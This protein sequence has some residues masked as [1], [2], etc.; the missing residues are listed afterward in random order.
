MQVKD[1]L[2]KI[3]SK[4][5]INAITTNLLLIYYRNN[6]SFSDIYDINGNLIRESTL[7]DYGLVV[8]ETPD[9]FFEYIPKGYKIQLEKDMQYDFIIKY[10]NIQQG[11]FND[12]KFDE[13]P[14]EILED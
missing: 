12:D 9:E 8:K 3:N 4:N 10:N 2:E 13:V 1:I 11:Y 6:Y 14:I 7:E 5:K